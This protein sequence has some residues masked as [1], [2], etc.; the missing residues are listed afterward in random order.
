[1]STQV[2]P[3]GSASSAPPEPSIASWTSAGPGSIVIRTSAAPATSAAVRPQRAPCA[4][5]A[6]ASSARRSPA[7][8]A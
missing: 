1:M 5:A 3:A 6:S 4:P 7:V 2:A 8:T